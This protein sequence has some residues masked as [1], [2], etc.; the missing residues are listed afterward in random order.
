[1]S[2]PIPVHLKG[3]GCLVGYVHGRLPELPRLPAGECSFRVCQSSRAR[4]GN[5]RP[6][7]TVPGVTVRVPNWPGM[8]SYTVEVELDDGRPAKLWVYVASALYGL[9]EYDFRLL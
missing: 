9:P 7:I 2:E 8:M 4:Y 5:A 1:M 3:T 6:P